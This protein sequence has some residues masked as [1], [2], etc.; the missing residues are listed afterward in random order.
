M[1]SLHE[2][3]AS[4]AQGL[5]TPG[6]DDVLAHLILAQRMN[7]RGGLAVYR[8]NVFQNYRNALRD[9][10]P[11]IERLVGEDFFLQAVDAF[12]RTTPSTSGDVH[13]YGDDFDAFLR[14]YP[15]A[16]ELVYL[17]DVAALEWAVHRAYHAATADAL[18][19][20]TLATMSDAALA[21]LRF[22]LNPGCQLIASPWPLLTIWRVNQPDYAGEQT[23]DLAMGGEC[24][25]VMRRGET[26]EPEPLSVAEHV[27]LAAFQAGAS[28]EGA[29]EAALAQDAAFD[30]GAFLQRHVL[31]GTFTNFNAE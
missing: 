18:D 1:P 29:L 2:L 30:L 28:L 11:V 6:N 16:T 20:A 13:D 14:D 31:A 9:T 22:K 23:V 10:Y 15:G 21:S 27:A 26:V 3:Q 8:N 19:A 5:M 25:L 24:A 4:F 12:I 17:R 7:A